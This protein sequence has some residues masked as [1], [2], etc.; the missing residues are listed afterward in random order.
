G[1]LS[2]RFGRKLLLSL[3]VAGFTVASALCGAAVSLEQMVLFRTLQGVFGAALVPL[4]QSMMLDL[5]TDEERGRALAMWGMGVMVGPILGPTLGGWL[6]QTYDWRWIFYINVPFGIVSFLGLALFGSET[7]KDKVRKFAGYGFAMLALAAAGIQLMLDRGERVGWFDSSEIVIYAT[8]AFAGVILFLHHMLISKN[9]FIDRRIFHDRNFVVGTIF[10]FSIA[11]VMFTTLALQPLMLQ[12]L[13]GHPVLA[14]GI[15][16]APRGFGMMI[17]MF[18]SG[19]MANHI[20]SRLLMG[21]GLTLTS[22]A[23]YE[24]SRFN[25]YT[26]D[27]AFI[28]TGIVQ[29]IGIGTVFVALNLVSYATLDVRLRSEAAAIANAVRTFGS[30]VGISVVFGF[31]IHATQ[32][33]HARLTENVTWFNDTLRGPA[34]PGLWDMATEQGRAAF[35]FELMRQAQMMAF[36]TNFQLIFFATL[37]IFPLLLFIRP[38]KRATT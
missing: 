33:N 24:M 21:F 10:Y 37:A 23:T 29:G 22:F 31:L 17:G 28:W 2:V 32:V 14:T 12:N 16:I 6:T 34:M 20:D 3:S 8:V 1:F 30:S 15:L 26:Q 18:L 7:P 19:R 27:V 5:Y 13:M 25:L 38:L 36:S 35:D 9:P 11:S 4:T